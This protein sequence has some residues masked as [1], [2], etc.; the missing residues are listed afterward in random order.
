MFEQVQ[1]R[2]HA[3][4]IEK[5]EAELSAL[6]KELAP[7]DPISAAPK[8]RFPIEHHKRKGRTL[9][10]GYRITTRRGSLYDG[11]LEALA[12]GG[13]LEQ[14]EYWFGKFANQPTKSN[15][16][17]LL[18]AIGVYQ[19]EVEAMLRANA[20]FQEHCDKRTQRLQRQVASGNSRAAA[21]LANPD[22]CKSG[23]WVGDIAEAIS[24]LLGAS[25]PRQLDAGRNVRTLRKAGLMFDAFL[26]PEVQPILFLYP[27]KHHRLMAKAFAFI[28]E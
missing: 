22:I 26:Q 15:A 5:L 28:E 20:A 16:Q 6:R 12:I 17:K 4:K 19:S 9:I 27:R 23:R 3:A 2:E 14:Q 25:N 18:G 1:S 8:P 21:I 11:I 7:E 10:P 13:K 24:I